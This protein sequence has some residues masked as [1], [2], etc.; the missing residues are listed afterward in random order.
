MRRT[1]SL[2]SYTGIL[3]AS[4]HK[5]LKETGQIYGRS[6]SRATISAIQLLMQMHRQCPKMRHRK[7]QRSSIARQTKR[8][9]AKSSGNASLISQCTCSPDDV[10]PVQNHQLTCSYISAKEHLELRRFLDFLQDTGRDRF[11]AEL[12]QQLE[13]LQARK[14]AGEAH[15]D[16][17]ESYML[18]MGV[19][20]VKQWN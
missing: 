2:I 4:H 6:T 19:E 8:V 12:P 20:H 10:S 5:A 1:E 18:E 3:T 13:E 17:L 16:R 15:L 14:H 11:F 9:A 7:M